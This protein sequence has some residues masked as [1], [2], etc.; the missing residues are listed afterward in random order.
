MSLRKIAMATVMGACLLL[1]AH[2]ASAAAIALT[3]GNV[4]IVQARLESLGYFTD[5]ENGV[6]GPATRDAIA[7][8]QRDHGLFANAELDYPT[9]QVLMGVAF[10][11]V[12]QYPYYAYAAAAPAYVGNPNV[13]YYQS[14]TPI[15]GYQPL[16]TYTVASPTYVIAR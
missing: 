15:A 5:G 16:A 9:Y 13:T 10:A 14:A 8:F 2:D 12:I 11:P 4:Q 6:M 3:V 7:N 1:S